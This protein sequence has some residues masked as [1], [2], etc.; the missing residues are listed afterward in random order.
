MSKKLSI[1]K[2][3][4]LAVLLITFFSSNA[5]NTL[6]KL[7][8]TS[9][10]PATVAYSLRLL[11]SSYTGPLVRISIGSNYY[12]VYP[13]DISKQFAL[14][15]KISSAY[16]TYNAVATGVTTNALSSVIG[17]SSAKVAIW[18]D[19]SGSAKNLTEGT[20]NYQ[21]RI[22]NSGVI[23]VENGKPFIRF[24][25]VVHGTKNSLG[26]ATQLSNNGQIVAVNKFASTNG[27]L[28]GAGGTY[29]WHS[30]SP[31][32]LISTTY[33]SLSV[34]NATIYQ[35]GA[36]KTASNAVWNTVLGINCVAPQTPATGTIW[37]NI[38]SDRGALNVTTGGGGYTEL[39]SFST[40]LSNT[41]RQTLENNQGVFYSI[42]LPGSSNADLSAL[43]L[44]SGTLSPTFTSANTSYTASV[45]NA[46]SSITVT[47][48][49][50]DANASITV[51]GSTVTSGTASGSIILSVGTN[52]I[53]VVV[54]AQNASTKT[55]TITVTRAA[56]T[57]TWAGTTSSDWNTASNW[58]LV[59]VPISTD[60]VTIP[61]GTPFAPNNAGA[62][63]IAS[64]T[65]NGG[66]TVTNTGTINV[67][68]ALNNT[69]TIS[70]IVTLNGSSAQVIT[71][72]GSIASLTLNNSA[73]ATISSGSISITE[74][75]TVTSGTLSTGGFLTLK[76]TARI[77]PITG[78]IS[79][80][81]TVE[82][83][84]PAGKRGFRFLTSPVT[85]TNFIKGNWQEGA[86]NTSLLYSSNQNPVANYGTHITGST[87]GLNGFD[88][89][90]TGNA[91]M[92]QFNNSTQLWNTGIA[93]TNATNLIAGNAYRILVRGNRSFDL[94]ATSA[95]N[96]ATT[97][98]ATGTLITG[99]V[100]FGT[101]SSS[102]SSLPTLAS[103]A[104][105]YSFIG[106]PY[107]SPINWN[108]LTKTGLTGYYYIWDPTLG[109]RGA[110]VSCFTD[111][112]KSNGSSAITTAIQS[113]QAFFVQNT[114]G[115]SARQLDIAE[116]NKTTGNT[117]VFR[118]TTGTSTLGIQLHLTS[119]TNG[120]SQDG[121]TVLFN[122]NYSNAVNDDDATK[123]TNQDENIAVQRGSSL[124]SIERRNV[125]ANPSDTVQLKTWQLTQNNYTFRIAANNFDGTVNAYLQD[126]YLNNETLLN[127][128]GTT[129]VNFTTTSTAATIA[130]DRFRIVFRANNS[131]PSTFLSVTAAQKNAGIEV[132]WNTANEVNMNSYE[133][134]ESADGINFTK[135]TSVAANNATTNNYTWF[136]AT[137]I[138][139]DNFYRIKSVEK[140]GTAKYSNVVKVK[141][142]G[143]GTEFTVYPNPVKGG[144]VSLQ[145]SNVEK[146]IYTVKIFNNIGQEVA[147]KTI[148][149][150]GS[151]ATQTIDLGKGIATGT[152]N[153]Q[154]TNGTTVITKT[155]IV[156]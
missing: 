98:R 43:T 68:G 81:V 155:V 2:A 13:D 147:S 120:I 101:A 152:Y 35:N 18:Y 109:T 148:S 133:V 89:T 156:E 119:N 28:L 9:A 51:N 90:L 82:R 76:G 67:T 95:S 115:A 36:S 37:D 103:N 63:T 33:A 12:D 110:Y 149:H 24:F 87:T 129:D 72:T 150:N 128:N 111:G 85:T 96:T 49:K 60:S 42:T 92:F 75:L 4:L 138:N 6:D 154:I 30:G 114:S 78:A 7:G 126:N 107:A 23:D 108:A 83:Y 73:G 34:Q 137:V 62:I 14:T 100:S 32:T 142:G 27:F 50:S 122:N 69:G 10:T 58:N 106:N 139:G 144:I 38:G 1:F 5:Q 123:F 8:L 153:M 31:T 143:K 145:M 65:V 121:A 118:T 102:P 11:S 124:M 3:V 127:L 39:L 25:G 59:S 21:P 54:T 131:L 130:T 104:S 41:V 97:L 79:G 141:L 112:T 86:N 140:S 113:G 29:D 135:A 64:L 53:N 26:L 116:A 17:S 99:A 77:A 52:T 105:E 19:Q 44:S 84:I 91:S 48:T 15:S 125:P 55:Y 45:S 56:G 47:P 70:G 88:A 136:D 57:K 80:N 134:E 93:N 16:S 46:T 146:G 71:G 74:T 132:S 151:S 22:I 40:A 94:T 117:N 20:S 66:V 61:S